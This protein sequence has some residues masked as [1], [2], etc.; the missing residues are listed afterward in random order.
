MARCALSR[1]AR[2]IRRRSIL[3]G[4]GDPGADTPARS[5]ADQPR[6]FRDRAARLA[7]LRSATEVL[8]RARG[9]GRRKRQTAA[10]LSAELSRIKRFFDQAPGRETCPAPPPARCSRRQAAG[11]E[12]PALAL[13]AT[14]RPATE[15]SRPIATSRRRGRRLSPPSVPLVRRRRDRPATQRVTARH[16]RAG[17]VSGPRRGGSS[18]TPRNTPPAL[19][20]R[21]EATSKPLS[22]FAAPRPGRDR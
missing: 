9:V 10:A 2:W 17:R 20:D 1:V 11:G 7:F 16:S 14:W 21:E 19:D 13:L 6:R 18:N 4:S 3:C 8:A 22:R 15:A 12:P 5:R